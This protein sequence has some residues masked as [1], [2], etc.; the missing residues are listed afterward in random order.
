MSPL[1]FPVILL[2]QLVSSCRNYSDSC[3]DMSRNSNSL[4]V[5]LE[6]FPHVTAALE[7]L[8]IG[9]PADPQSP[10]PASLAGKVQLA[11]YRY[12]S[13]HTAR[14]LSRQTH[15]SHRLCCLRD[16]RKMLPDIQ[17]INLLFIQGVL[18]FQQFD[19]RYSILTKNISLWHSFVFCNSGFILKQLFQTG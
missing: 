11:L 6:L 10:T 9:F 7:F 3:K 18:I 16:H 2:P 1:S 12:P 14:K 19:T 15:D 5:P 13:Q 17:G 8:N 4:E